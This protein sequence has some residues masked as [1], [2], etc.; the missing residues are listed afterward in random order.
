MKRFEEYFFNENESFNE[1]QQN[2]RANNNIF[3]IKVID[4]DQKIDD[5]YLPLTYTFEIRNTKA[6]VNYVRNLVKLH[7]EIVKP[8]IQENQQLIEQNCDRYD[9]FYLFAGQV[10]SQSLGKTI[11]DT[12]SSFEAT[13]HH[14]YKSIYKT[15]QPLLASFATVGHEIGHLSHFR[16]ALNIRSITIPIRQLHL[17]LNYLICFFKNILNSYKFY[18]MF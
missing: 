16:N 3:T 10:N 9:S 4:T 7:N 12:R 6:E 15:N 1:Y 14:S 2:K 11:H 18:Y 5:K 8:F 13:L 17:D